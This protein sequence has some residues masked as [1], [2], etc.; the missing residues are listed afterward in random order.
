[1]NMEAVGLWSGLFVDPEREADGSAERGGDDQVCGDEG[2]RSAV[3]G[4][5]VWEKKLGKMGCVWGVF[6]CVA[7]KEKMELRSWRRGEAVAEGEKV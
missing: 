6:G 7:G 5:L 1:M 2:G 3:A 4:S